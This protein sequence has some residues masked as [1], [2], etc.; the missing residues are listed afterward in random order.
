MNEDRVLFVGPSEGDALLNPVGGQMIRKVSDADS[1]GTYSLFL[2]VLPP[3]APGP[4]SHIHYNHDETFYVLE[5]TLTVCAGSRTFTIPA[6]GMILVPRGL[7]HKPANHEQVP[8]RFLLHFSPGGMD[9]FFSEAAAR[10]IPF[11]APHDPAM[12][13]TLDDFSA[14]YGFA[15]A[16][17][18]AKASS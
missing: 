10:H 9:Q 8:A 14:K 13:A 4:Y 15:F 3:L 18:S 17:L 2:N 6:G 5:G 12:H 1:A 11:Q 7:A 16:E